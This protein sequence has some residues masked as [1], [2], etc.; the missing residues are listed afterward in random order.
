MTAVAIS[1]IR[2]N[3]T[4]NMANHQTSATFPHPLDTFRFCLSPVNI[5]N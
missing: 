5:A 4:F 3:Y 2:S 1:Y